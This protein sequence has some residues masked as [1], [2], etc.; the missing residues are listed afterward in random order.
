[1]YPFRT[2]ALQNN[3]RFLHNPE[4]PKK[5]IVWFFALFSL[6]FFLMFLLHVFVRFSLFLSAACAIF[7]FIGHRAANERFR[8]SHG[9]LVAPLARSS[10]QVQRLA[11]PSAVFAKQPPK[12]TDE[13]KQIHSSISLSRPFI[14]A[15]RPSSDIHR[16]Q[17]S[18][19]TDIDQLASESL[20]KLGIPAV[21][22][23]RYVSNFKRLISQVILVK[24][25]RK[26]HSDDPI[27]EMMLAVPGYENCRSY[28]L[29][30]ISGLAV[31]QFLAG[32]YGDRGARWYDREWTTDLPSD[33][34]IVLHIL[35]V[36]LSYFMCGRRSG[37]IQMR[38][39]Q[40]YLCI[41]RDPQIENEDDI[42]LCSDNG[43]DFY[44]FTRQSQF[45]SVFP[46]KFYVFPGR[47][48]MYAGLTLL[49][50][51]VKKKQRFL[52]E[53]ADL[54]EPPMCMDQVFSLTRM[55]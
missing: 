34:Q 49:F 31:S 50:W 10:P 27:I 12:E 2:R 37:A 18:S 51:F 53:G 29:Q 17:L 46:D 25:V 6:A 55:N 23:T 40:K 38:F 26:I 16:S 22:F 45:D 13:L 4:E 7:A 41:N 44:V 11:Q 42:L 35:S 14:A 19:T 3:L 20:S 30:R 54:T 24:L 8:T 43:S 36:W 9:V 28:I 48:A 21:A 32:H 47:D 5:R 15:D 33:N 52:L 1:M 39:S